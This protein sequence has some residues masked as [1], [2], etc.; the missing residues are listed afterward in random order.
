[1]L[2]TH[3]EL[4]VH[5]GTARFAHWRGDRCVK[6]WCQGRY[7]LAVLPWEVGGQLGLVLCL[8]ERE[9]KD[10][11]LCSQAWPSSVRWNAG[12]SGQV[13]AYFSPSTAA[14]TS[15]PVVTSVW[16]LFWPCCWVKLW[17]FGVLPSSQSVSRWGSGARQGMQRQGCLLRGD[18]KDRC[19]VCW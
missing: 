9:I 7:L 1:M 10:I 12:L 15:F 17:Q 5:G 6:R 16:S 8:G 18:W 2:C 11:S 14:S 4:R 13:P 3:P 19:C